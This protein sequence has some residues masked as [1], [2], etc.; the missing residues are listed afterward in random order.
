M[1]APWAGGVKSEEDKVR[2]LSYSNAT[3]RDVRC[4][5]VRI[6]VPTNTDK[7]KPRKSPAFKSRTFQKSFEF[8]WGVHSK[9]F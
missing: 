9:D 3:S 5:G 7:T 6:G 8:F 4:G 1:A 2:G